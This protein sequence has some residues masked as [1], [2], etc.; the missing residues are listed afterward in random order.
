VKREKEM[1]FE[2]LEAEEEYFAKYKPQGNKI[3]PSRKAA[4]ILI[5][6]LLFIIFYLVWSYRNWRKISISKVKRSQ[7][8]PSYFHILMF[9]GLE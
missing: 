4:M 5:V 8:R 6:F 9:L 1:D 3:F 7:N 2:E